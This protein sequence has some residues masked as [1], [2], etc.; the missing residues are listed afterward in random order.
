MF[1][2]AKGA[3]DEAYKLVEN[4]EM[5]ISRDTSGN[6][7]IHNGGWGSTKSVEELWGD[8]W[9]EV[10]P[11]AITFSESPADCY[12]ARLSISCQRIAI[13]SVIGL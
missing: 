12:A 1:E 11:K 10:C 9:S 13:H 7:T 3:I 8:V 6:V 2:D 4:Q 5:D